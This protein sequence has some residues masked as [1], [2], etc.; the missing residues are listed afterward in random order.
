M[1]DHLDS[2]RRMGREGQTAIGLS[3]QEQGAYDRGRRERD[4]ALNG[5][6][7]AGTS[8]GG[9]GGGAIAVIFLLAAMAPA[10]VAPGLALWLLWTHFETT[11]GWDW[12]VLLAICGV[13][14][15]ALIWVGVQLWRRVPAL[16]LALV[17]SLYLGVSYGIC[18]PGL[19]G[20]DIWWTGTVSIAVAA[21]GYWIGLSA[22][23]RWMSSFPITTAV[24]LGVGL[25]L[26]LF[27]LEIAPRMGIWVYDAMALKWA[28][29]GL[30]IGAA[31]RVIARSKI[32]ILGLIALVGAGLFLAPGMLGD[33][34]NFLLLPPGPQYIEVESY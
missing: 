20:T 2:I 1:D 15:I 33:I 17:L 34:A 26:S 19:F 28:G 30:A 8:G 13:A 16:I 21:A 23:N 18:M 14:G 11:Q 27:V 4:Q 32:A 10:F 12:P 22:P 31:L 9:E 29:G 6:R 3:V 24:A 7:P 25:L 5:F